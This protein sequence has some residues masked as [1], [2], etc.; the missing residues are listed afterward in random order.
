MFLCTVTDFPA[1]T[2]DQSLTTIWFSPAASFIPLKRLLL[3]SSRQF[4]CIF[5]YEVRLVEFYPHRGRERATLYLG[6]L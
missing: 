6:L 1:S 3:N 5:D 2:A 4:G